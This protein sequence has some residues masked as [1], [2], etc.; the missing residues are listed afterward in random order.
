MLDL[1][2]A[3]VS[4]LSSDGEGAVEVLRLQ[5]ER[6]PP[7]AFLGFV[8]STVP[9]CSPLSRIRQP[10]GV[11]SGTTSSLEATD[12]CQSAVPLEA[13]N[14]AKG[15]LPDRVK[16][17]VNLRASFTALAVAVEGNCTGGGSDES[18]GS[19]S[20]KSIVIFSRPVGPFRQLSLEV[21]ESTVSGCGQIT[22]ENCSH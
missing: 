2:D 11:T 20:F 3:G 5:N 1:P 13:N 6:K 16:C 15:L 14:L 12:F 22:S 19:N 17:L 10:I 4:L 21:F 8:S 7:V 9:R 18:S